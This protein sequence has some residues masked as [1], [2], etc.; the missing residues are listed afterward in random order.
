MIFFPPLDICCQSFCPFSHCGRVGVQPMSGD[1]FLSCSY[2]YYK[3]VFID[4]SRNKVWFTQDRCFEMVRYL[5]VFYKSVTRNDV[6]L[7]S[8]KIYVSG[9]HPGTHILSLKTFS[10][11]SQLDANDCSAGL[12]VCKSTGGGFQQS[13]RQKEMMFLRR[14]V[15]YSC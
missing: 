5:H 13:F 7:D 15:N 6:T 10:L 14:Q 4:I 1:V 8:L 3:L 12:T 9:L 11:Q 2:N